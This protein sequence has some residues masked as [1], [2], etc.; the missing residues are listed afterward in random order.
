VIRRLRARAL[1]VLALLPAALVAAQETPPPGE[2]PP[3]QEQDDPDD[4]QETPPP[5]QP[6]PEVDDG[7]QEDPAPAGEQQDPPPVPDTPSDTPAPVAEPE[8]AGEP[9]AET[10]EALPP[11]VSVTYPASAD[12]LDR[13]LRALVAAHPT[14]TALETLG[15]STSGREILALSIRLEGPLPLADR[16]LLLVLDHQGPPTPAAEAL[17]AVANSLLTRCETEPELRDLLGRT[18]LV[19]APALDPDVRIPDLQARAV[20]FDRNFPSGWQP[21]SV[22]RGAGA[23]SLSEPET[24]A[25][26]R[27]LST[28]GQ[29]AIV[30]GFA[31]PAPVRPPYAGSELPE[32]DHEV[33]ARLVAALEIPGR[34]PVIPWFELGSPGGGL[35]DYAFQACG[36]LPLVVPVAPAGERSPEALASW[37]A[38]V[39]E[40]VVACLRLLPQL[41][42]R[43]ESLE[44]LAPDTWQLDLVL[45]NGGLVPTLSARG[46]E[47]APGADVTLDVR[48]AKLV[49]SALRGE[50]E[51]S[52]QDVSIPVPGRA[53]L[54]AGTL[55][56][57]ERR[58]LRLVLEGA[59]GS[60]IEVDARSPWGGSASLSLTLP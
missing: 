45:A 33:L 40:R 2:S 57:G 50:N 55:A 16:P 38:E 28:R 1:V 34:P 5:P 9:P 20:H 44:R 25:A 14:A 30:L 39:E 23:I 19:L 4:P 29:A 35:L 47:R 53:T 21:A 48:G 17:V 41:E 54:A 43:Q 26:A 37:N 60:A 36:I 15:R 10:V 13:A 6:A 22:R 51:A 42:L 56:G 58:F 7:G 46:H 32:A 52:F 18:A 31:A 49:A 59:S 27:F 8:A 11:S 24:L 12:D 3:A